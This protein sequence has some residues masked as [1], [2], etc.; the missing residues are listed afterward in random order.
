MNKTAIT[1]NPNTYRRIYSKIQNK[2]NRLLNL[3]NGAARTEARTSG[4]TMYMHS[5]GSPG[6][7]IPVSLPKAAPEAITAFNERPADGLLSK[8]RQIVRGKKNVMKRNITRDK[9]N[10]TFVDTK[11]LK[12]EE[13]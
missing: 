11:D 8:V 1:I 3:I 2:P 6:E 9:I 7:V 5:V 13:I 4:R 10:T 12:D